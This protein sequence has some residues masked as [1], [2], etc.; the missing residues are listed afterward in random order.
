MNGHVDGD[1]YTWSGSPLER[2]V[3]NTMAARSLDTVSSA[4]VRDLRTP[5]QVERD[6]IAALRD[7]VEAL[8]RQLYDQAAR[9]DRAY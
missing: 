4:P 3:F 6:D 9:L 2:A 7:E 5:D 8:R 1:D